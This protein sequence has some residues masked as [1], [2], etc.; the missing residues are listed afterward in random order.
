MGNNGSSDSESNQISGILRQLVNI[1]AYKIIQSDDFK[2]NA[3]KILL[4]DRLGFTIEE[5]APIIGT[6]VG[7]V[8][9]ELS[10]NKSKRSEN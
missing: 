6:T 7:T 5:I 2:N 10:V 3:E 9:K 8:R 4:L 1:E